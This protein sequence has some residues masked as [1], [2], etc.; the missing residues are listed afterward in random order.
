[1]SPAVPGPRPCGD[2]D[3]VLAAANARRVGLQE[4]HR[5]PHVQRTPAPHAVTTVI[6]RA[7]PPAHTAA[8]SLSPTR[9][10]DDHQLAAHADANVLDDG[11]PQTHQPPPY[12]DPAHV[13]T[14]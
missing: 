5:R 11:V 4:H 3:P 13:A 7:T 12:P 8:I 14:A 2:H 1:M 6:A 10:H 9:P